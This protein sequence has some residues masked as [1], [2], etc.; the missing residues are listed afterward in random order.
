MEVAASVDEENSRNSAVARPLRSVRAP[1]DTTTTTQ[2]ATRKTRVFR[3]YVNRKFYDPEGSR[4]VV[5][6]CQE[7][8][9]LP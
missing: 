9:D 7:F 8:D 6:V 3:R 4:Y 1:M 2:T 5:A